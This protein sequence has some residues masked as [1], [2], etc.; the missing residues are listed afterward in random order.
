MRVGITAELL[1]NTEFTGIEN[2]IFNLSENLSLTNKHDINLIFPLET[3]SHKDVGLSMFHYSP[4]LSRIKMPFQSCL[5][6]SLI[7]YP[8]ELKGFN[9]IHIPTVT[10][11]FFFRPLGVKVVMTVHDIIPNLFPKWHPL[12]RRLYFKYFLKYRFKFV[13]RFITVSENTK[14]DLINFFNINENKIDV[15]CAGVSKNYQQNLELNKDDFIL[16][17]S[18]LEPRKNFKRLIDA[19]IYLKEKYNIVEKLYIVGKEGW[20]FKGIL[21]IPQKY[22]QNIIFKGYVSEEELIQLYQTAKLFVYPSFYEGFGLPVLEA[23]ACG[24]PVITSNTSSLPEVGGDAA[25][26]VNPEDTD[27]VAEKIYQV[28]SDQNLQNDMSQ[29][30]VKQAG[31]FSWEKCA[32]ETIRVYERVMNQ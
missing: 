13:E 4:P 3:V 32:Q 5:I 30:G 19:Y 23:M 22:K 21:N 7:N 24:C 15:V 25:L 8:R 28:L 29:K 26:Y 14:K 6:A 17:V 11:P 27:Q 20:F 16:G 12:K 9:V 31:K 10:A 2:Y 1:L 18:T